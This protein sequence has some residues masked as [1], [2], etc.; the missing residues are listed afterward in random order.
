M[1]R[2]QLFQSRL[3][4]FKNQFEQLEGYFKAH[5]SDNLYESQSNYYFLFT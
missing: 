4:Y 2:V 3:R 5:D 1:G